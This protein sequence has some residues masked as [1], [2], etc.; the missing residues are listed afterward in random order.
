MRS[1]VVRHKL[2]E[3]EV[4]R[5]TFSS[6]R[7]GA[8]ALKGGVRTLERRPSALSYSVSA[9]PGHEPRGAA[10]HYGLRDYPESELPIEANVLGF[11]GLQVRQRGAIVHAG[12][13]LRQ[14]GGANSLAL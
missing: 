2:F 11:V 12:A 1:T 10:L 4:G 6:A 13:K 14:Q 7:R 9:W 3:G 5:E 8:L